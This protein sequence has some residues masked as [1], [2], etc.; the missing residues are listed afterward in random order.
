MESRYSC[1]CGPHP[2]RKPIANS[3][4]WLRRM[5]SH[6]LPDQQLGPCTALVLPTKD[7][8]NSWSSSTSPPSQ[9]ELGAS[10]L[11]PLPQRV[12]LAVLHLF[13]QFFCLSG[14]HLHMAFIRAM[15]VAFRRPHVCTDELRLTLLLSG[16]CHTRCDANMPFWNKLIETSLQKCL[17]QPP[18][19][20]DV[21]RV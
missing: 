1:L 15:S 2:T 4:G 6:L 19:P 17:T 14:T 18:K 11:F 9:E 13:N 10:T 3:Q 16:I 7:D 5:G 8:L 21:G 12:K 20:T